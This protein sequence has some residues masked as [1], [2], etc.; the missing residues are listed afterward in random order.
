MS[1]WP[2]ALTF[3]QGE[4][5]PHYFAHTFITTK[6]FNRWSHFSTIASLVGLGELWSSNKEESRRSEDSCSEKEETY[7][8]SFKS[9][10][11]NHK[12]ESPFF[13]SFILISLLSR[14]YDNKDR[15]S[16]RRN[17]L[18]ESK[19]ANTKIYM[20]LKG[21]EEI[22][23]LFLWWRISKDIYLKNRGAFSVIWSISF[24]W[25]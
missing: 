24:L 7:L 15:T 10:W 16:S 9:Y 18:E 5:S 1:R 4:V 8:K 19:D 14:K 25:Y 3:Q 2:L 20:T 11:G 17:T 23:I 21:T 22:E 12:E 6:I 13:F